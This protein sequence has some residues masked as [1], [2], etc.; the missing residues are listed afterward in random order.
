MI[1]GT[2]FSVD[3]SDESTKER[4]TQRKIDWMGEMRHT[5]LWVIV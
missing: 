5:N 4:G 1:T 2:T 3:E